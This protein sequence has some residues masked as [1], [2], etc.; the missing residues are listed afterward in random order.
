M[1]I[2]VQRQRKTADGILG[3]M[4][5]EGN[6]FSAFTVENLEHSIPA[7][8]YDAKIDHSPHI[9]INCPHLAVPA[10][11]KAAGGDAGIR[12]HPAN[13]PN[14]LLGCIA[15]GDRQEADAV[16][17]SQATFGKLMIILCAQSTLQVEVIDIV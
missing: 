1:K 17:D 14:Q 8:V 12:I 3:M 5:L 16:D 15:V 9:G 4:T 11:D 6:P 2:I 10:R 13:F 7:G